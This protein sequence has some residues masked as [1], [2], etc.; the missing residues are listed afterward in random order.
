MADMLRRACPKLGGDWSS[1]LAVMLPP[2]QNIKAHKHI[3]HTVLYY[4]SAAAPISITPEPGTI[5]YL[6]PGTV[7]SVDPSDLPR[8]SVAMLVDE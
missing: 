5:L 4:P 7:H 2:G 8:L 3:Q 6:P 1:Y